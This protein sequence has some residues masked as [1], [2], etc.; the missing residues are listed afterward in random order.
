MSESLE[1]VFAAPTYLS[2]HLFDSSSTIII[3]ASPDSAVSHRKNVQA[4]VTTILREQLDDFEMVCIINDVFAKRPAVENLRSLM[5]QL[6]KLMNERTFYAE[7]RETWP[8]QRL[9]PLIQKLGLSFLLKEKAVV[10]DAV[11]RFIY[12]EDLY[13]AE[14]ELEQK[15]A[16]AKADAPAAAPSSSSDVPAKPAALDAKAVFPELAKLAAMAELAE[17][18]PRRRH[19]SSKPQ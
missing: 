16:A 14:K 8:D 5:P 6:Y 10:D 17:P 9:C 12:R 11:A 15:D 19:G 13:L 4:V 1:R 7:W 18:K 2:T 3:M